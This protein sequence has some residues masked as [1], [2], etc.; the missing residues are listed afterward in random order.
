MTDDERFLGCNLFDTRKV[1]S[2]QFR[3]TVEK[4]DPPWKLHQQLED[5]R[6]EKPFFQYHPPPDSD[7]RVEHWNDMRADR[8]QSAF[9]D[10][11]LTG[12]LGTTLAEF[13]TEARHNMVAVLYWVSKGGVTQEP[14]DTYFARARPDI[15]HGACKHPKP[16]RHYCNHS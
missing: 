6:T 2:N 12:E 9:D 3:S 13:T 11:G 16:S 14:A 7:T 5:E 10:I 1:Y 4:M 8:Q 15:S